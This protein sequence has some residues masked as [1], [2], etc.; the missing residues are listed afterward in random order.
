MK[1]TLSLLLLAIFP[2]TPL[3]AQEA[4]SPLEGQMKILARGMRTVGNQIGDP[5]KQQ[6]NVALLETLKK[7]AT[8]SKTLEPRKTQAVPEA[9]RA[10]FL[11][12]YRTDLDKLKDALDQVE[13]A[14]KA[15]QYEKAK[16]LIATVNAIKKEGHGKFK[17]D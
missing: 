14:V 5:S 1:N 4:D 2:L 9:K 16:S 13:E 6:E 17:V 10:T 3:H 12:D 8:D 11:A 15:G 7:A